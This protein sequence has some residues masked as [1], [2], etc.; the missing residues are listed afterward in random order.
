MQRMYFFIEA[1]PPCAPQL[2]CCGALGGFSTCEISAVET[3]PWAQGVRS[4]PT[5][6]KSGGAGV[7]S[8]TCDCRRHLCFALTCEI[9]SVTSPA[10]QLVGCQ[11]GTSP[12]QT[13]TRLHHLGSAGFAKHLES[14]G[15]FLVLVWKV[16]GPGG[17]ELS[18]QGPGNS[19]ETPGVSGNPPTPN[20]GIVSVTGPPALTCPKI[21]K[22]PSKPLNVNYW[23][24]E[25]LVQ[26]THKV[27]ISYKEPAGTSGPICNAF[28]R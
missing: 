20:V 27:Q 8:Q 4:T 22:K 3:P 26:D 7:A 15:N 19:Q 24:P 12:S 6:L 18:K 5:T 9:S 23:I 13:S 21:I 10:N 1:L 16:R 28:K 11:V 2:Q 14:L 25:G 17:H